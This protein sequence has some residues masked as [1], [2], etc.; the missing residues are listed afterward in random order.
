MKTL[1]DSPTP[2]SVQDMC[3]F[4]SEYSVVLFSSGA[5]CIRM[6]RNLHRMAASQGM[7]VEFSILPRHIHITVTELDGPSTFTSIVSIRNSPISFC[8][9]ATLSKLSWQMADGR[10]DFQEACKLLEIIDH[11]PPTNPWMTLALVS[12]ANAAF[13]RLFGG[14]AVAMLI[15]FMATATG[16]LLKRVLT[17]IQVDTRIVTILCAL[18]STL[19]A[20]TDHLCSLGSTPDITIGTS[21]LYLVPGIPFINSFCDLLDCHY[22]CAFGRFMHA[23][24]IMCCLSLGLVVGMMIMNIGMF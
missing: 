5:T 21:V 17:S 9:I 15:V 1:H 19:I 16:F 23:V 13:C 20:A 22:L 3:I 7:K 11:T 4:L 2:P 14:D 6:D 8:K 10:I 24:V 12:A 18:L